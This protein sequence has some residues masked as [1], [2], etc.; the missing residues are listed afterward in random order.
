MVVGRLLSEKEGLF[1]GATV[2]CYAGYLFYMFYN[3]QTCKKH[4]MT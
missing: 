2:G 4:V 3:G 1:S